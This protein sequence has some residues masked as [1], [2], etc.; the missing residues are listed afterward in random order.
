MLSSNQDRC[1]CGVG[2]SA[3]VLALSRVI[4]GKGTG[5]GGLGLGMTGRSGSMGLRPI[6]RL[7]RGGLPRSLAGTE[8]VRSTG[9]AD[10]FLWLASVAVVM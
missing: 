2:G 5:V 9:G 7:R 10:R 8:W 6:Q 1:E 3:R 4:V